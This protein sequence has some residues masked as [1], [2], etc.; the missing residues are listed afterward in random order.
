MS[1][2]IEPRALAARLSLRWATRAKAF[3]MVLLT[4][5]SP[6][7]LAEGSAV[8]IQQPTY[9]I[10]GILEL[11]APGSQPAAAVL[12]L[13][14]TA[15]QKNE[16]GGLFRDLAGQLSDAGIASLRIDF[17]GNGDSPVGYRHYRLSTATRDAGSAVDFLRRQ[18]QIDADRIALLGFSQGGLIA[19]L[20]ILEDPQLSALATWSTVAGDGIGSFRDVFEQ[21]YATA[22]REGYVSI[23]YPWLD[24]PLQFD[25]QWFEELLTQ[26]SFSAMQHYP[27]PILAVAGTADSNVPYAQSVALVAQSANTQSRAVLI[28]GADHIF[29]V[30][31]DRP[32]TGEDEPRHRQLLAI[33]VDWLSTVLHAGR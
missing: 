23:A 22:Q 28:A 21:H 5:L 14:G 13:H 11:P 15:S 12:L 32:T 33:T 27:G 25:L 18:K 2:T 4:A 20:T 6:T 1:E 10:P 17:A 19:Q 31:D 9:A 26:Q 7:A 30:L 16:V 8:L 3:A 24:A 29:N